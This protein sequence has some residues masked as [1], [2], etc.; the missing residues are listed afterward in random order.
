[1]VQA[2]V[3]VLVTHKRR[4]VT[5]LLLSVTPPVLGGFRHFT[6]PETQVPIKKKPDPGDTESGKLIVMII[7]F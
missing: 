1:M 3:K 7:L 6:S 4:A 5:G 2:Y